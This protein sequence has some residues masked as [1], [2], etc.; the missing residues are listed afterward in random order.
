VVTK[1]DGSERKHVLQLPA[2]KIHFIGIGGAGMSAIAW[3]LLKKGYEISGSDLAE[4]VL[5]Q[6]L[7]N[8]GARIS[9][10]HHPDNI[11][12]GAL[13][14]V[15]SAIKA[16][17][18]ELAHA[19]QCSL[20]IWHRAR[21][22]SE[23]MNDGTSVAICGTHGKTTTT[24]M[25]S[26]LLESGGLDPTILI[27]G[28]VNDIGG[29]AKLG[30]GKYVVAEADESDGSFLSLRPNYAIITNIEPDHLDFYASFDKIL[31]AFASF[32]NQLKDG[33][34][35]I[36][37][38][39]DPGIQKLLPRLRVPTV[40]YSLEQPST[41]LYAGEISL[42]PYGSRFT[43]W[44]DGKACGEV[45]L[46]VPGRHNVSN[47]LASIGLA[48][49]LGV[50]FEDAQTHIPHFKGVLRRFQVK[51][52]SGGVSIIDDYAHHPT[53]VM[54][55]IRAALSLKEEQKGRIFAVFQPHRY[56][57]TKHLAREFGPAFAD[58]D[59]VVITDVY[60][61]GEPAIE[62][63][64]GKTIYESIA[65]AG[66]P[67]VSYVQ[68]AADICDHLIPM[69]KPCDIFLTLGAGDIWKVGEQLLAKLSSNQA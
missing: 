67:R 32:L 25:V 21:M 66:H 61:A 3:V 5:T 18:A 35:A 24:S 45:R 42:S 49:L 51:G 43:L 14:V 69:L 68:S 28:E 37:C 20:P 65:Q 36:L 13:V 39:D 60:S 63:I 23:L 50:K 38:V 9:I 10:G 8:H 1:H 40:L 41:E 6:R 34:V 53:E 16:T 54:A 11:P 26:L 44:K 29:N 33:G 4:N 62:G 52:L 15:S 27:G 30:K 46:S 7:R 47:A 48:M 59:V 58:A 31:E 57:R 17:N 64:S 19:Q 56:T 2:N 12:Q 22:L 55:T